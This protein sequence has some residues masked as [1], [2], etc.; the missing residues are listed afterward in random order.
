MQCRSNK[1]EFVES[2]RCRSSFKTM[3]LSHLSKR[4]KLN[5]V[6]IR[7]NLYSFL[8]KKQRLLYRLNS[9]KQIQD[10]SDSCVYFNHHKASSAVIVRLM[11]KIKIANISSIAITHLLP[12]TTEAEAEQA[13]GCAVKDFTVHNMDQARGTVS[14]FP[15]FSNQIGD[16]SFSL[17][18]INTANI[19]TIKTEV[20]GGTV[21]KQIFHLP[22]ITTMKSIGFNLRSLQD[23]KASIGCLCRVHVYGE[24]ADKDDKK[25]RDEEGQQQLL[26]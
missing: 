26:M 1:N 19:M 23:K 17:D 14:N 22:A 2:L 18:D 8:F 20:S 6:V 25:R 9:N 16:F 24:F 15:S 11:G 12:N 7:S 3:Q 13:R 4:R 21:I 5:I 10:L